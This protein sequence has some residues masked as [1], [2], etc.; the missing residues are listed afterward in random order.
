MHTKVVHRAARL[1]AD[2]FSLAAL[3][4]NFRGVGRSEGVH[5]HGRGEALDLLAA[6]RFVRGQFPGGPLVLGGF[7][8]GSVCALAASRVARPD[9]LYL[10]GFPL[11]TWDR[12]G[13]EEGTPYPVVWIQG[14][15]DMFCD[16]EMARATAERYG[17]SL[18]LVPGADHFFT[19][20]LEVFENASAEAIGKELGGC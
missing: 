8:F 16:P 3:R 9:L 11:N 20:R 12:R 4:F 7:S 14:E 15:D 13:A 18:S 5:D 17:W 6:V 1:L 2:R 10:I 19:D